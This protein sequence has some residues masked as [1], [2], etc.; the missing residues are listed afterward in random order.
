MIQMAPQT[1]E[2]VDHA[3]AYIDIII[4]LQGKS[5]DDHNDHI[6]FVSCE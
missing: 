6:Q 5:K 3:H 1:E 2:D 4:H